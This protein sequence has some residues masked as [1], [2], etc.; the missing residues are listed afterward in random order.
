MR[1]GEACPDD[2]IAIIG[3]A[4]R[5]PGADSPEALWQIVRD[6]RDA[7][8]RFTDEQLAAAG[9]DAATLADPAYVRAKGMVAEADGFDAALFGLSPFEAALMD[10]QQRLFVECAWMALEDAAVD[11]ARFDGAVGMFAGSIL[12]TYLL[13]NL[14]PNRALAQQAGSFQLAVGNDPTFLA[15]R[16]SYLLGLTGPSTSVGTAC[17]TGLTAVHLAC[18]SL[19]AH[20][21]D[22]AL[23]G[24]A[25]VHLPLVAGY[26]FEPGSILS[27]DGHCRPFDAEAQGTVS[28]DGAGAVALRRLAD[29]V[30][31]G[32]PIQAVILGSAINNDGHDKVGFTAPSV[33]PQARV[34][35]E[36][37]TVAGVAPESIA[38]IEA[39]AAG[40]ALGDPIEVAALAEVFAHAPR[41]TPCAIGSIKSNIGHVDAA[42]GIA[43]LIK[44]VLA[45][46]HR[47]LP[48]TA[49]YCAP[50]P[51]LA[52]GSS[53][54]VLGEARAFDAEAPMRAGVSAFG[55]G[56]TNVHIV[57]EEYV[58][59]PPKPAAQGPELLL[60]SA[61]SPGALEATAQR[62]ANHL[63]A[64]P[65]LSLGD[66]AH[67][68]R[69]GRRPLPYRSFVVARD[70]GDAIA[71]LRRLE[72]GEMPTVGSVAFLFPGLGDH[73]P[74]MGWELYCTQPL[75]RREVDRCAALLLPE[76]GGDIR[77]H[78]FAR[79]DWRHPE[80][81]PTSDAPALDLRAMLGRTT[82]EESSLDGPRWGQ[83]A[84]FV[85]EYALAQLLVDWGAVPTT[86]A[87]YSIGEFVAATLAG[88]FALPDAL[89]LVAAR[90]QLID[91]RVERG[92]MLAVSIGEAALGALLPREVSIAAVNGPSLTIAAGPVDAIAAL[93]RRLI[94]EEVACQHLPATHAYHSAMMAPIV[95][96]LANRVAAAEPQPPRTPW[97]SCLTGDWIRAE[98]AIDPHYWAQHLCRTVRFHQALEP[99]LADPARILI[100]LG[101]GQSLT[102]HALAVRTR[103]GRA[104]PVI[105]AMRW[106]YGGDGEAATLQRAV[107]QLWAAGATLDFGRAFARA[108]TRRIA[109]PTYAFQRVRHWIDPPAA[110]DPVETG[111][112]AVE[113]WFSLPCWK[114]APLTQ[115]GKM[116]SGDW[117]IFADAHG[118]GAEL[119]ER[120]R[121]RGGRTILVRP[122]LAFA[123]TAD[124]FTVAPGDAADYGA[125]VASLSQAGD[126]PPNIAHC[127]AL[128]A[129]RDFADTQA[130]G[131]ES[132]VA[133]LAALWR[134]D[135]G[136]SLRVEV[137]ASG[138]ADFGETVPEKATLL[139]PVLVAPQERPGTRCRCIDL[140]PASG[141]AV[142]AVVAE[143][144][145]EPTA[146]LV[147]YRGKARWLRGYE[148]VRLGPVADGLSP[149]RDRGVY[150]ITGGLGGVGLVLARHL[151]ERCAARL[152]LVGRTSLGEGPARRIA[153]VQALEE[154][155]AEVLTLSADVADRAAMAKVFAAAEARFGAVQ[156]VFHCAGS[157]GA[158]TFCEMARMTSADIDAQL[159]AKARG[160]IVL[161][162]V[163]AGRALD[164][165]VLMS[166]LSAV[167][168]GLGF[169]A[170]AAANC[171]LDAFAQD[172]SRVRRTRWLSIDWD[173]WR[174]GE[175]RAAVAGL[176]GTVAD[177]FMQGGEAADACERILAVAGVP[178]VVVSSGD[179]R[180]RLRQWVEHW[181]ETPSAT[182]HARPAMRSRH[183]APR[184]PVEHELAQIWQSLFLIEGIGVDDNFFELGG[185]SLL[186]TQLNARIAR[187]L[188][189]ELSLAGILRAPTIAALAEAVRAA[190]SAPDA[191][192]LLA[193]LDDAEI[194]RLLAVE[195][196]NG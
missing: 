185:N 22:L 75:F 150:L 35:A 123:A 134:D 188:G 116:P 107:G 112:R 53:F 80:L 166:S 8:T 169:A 168:G 45:L 28:S 125:L 61:R 73:Y 98:E 39:H 74:A 16:T 99:L 159:H 194:E 147:T 58:P 111:R 163:I 9:V 105:P 109:L 92:A 52:L 87:G 34:I 174:L 10:P 60:L 129:H 158:D 24:A 132:V 72:P 156:G 189:V 7:I 94:A 70:C 173:S 162:Q 25:S 128:D 89:A 126:V 153:A 196:G 179:L 108:D 13:R 38:L 14:W 63:Q 30:A 33:A 180:Q 148:P 149:L 91:E 176:G 164:F 136:R 1:A 20:E 139:G 152:V 104:N 51:R 44:A 66:V 41:K 95:V 114:P 178:N 138:V 85:V 117:L 37:L 55:I 160:A 187:T 103:L 140:D 12:S 79:H 90:A 127:W 175:T 5:F 157:I 97:V 161:D 121:P 64:H 11:P 29:A 69:S 143:L 76:L 23:A 130:H 65:E 195:D 67:T 146:P 145:V 26:R 32:D 119:A 142:D 172:R 78:L 42:A 131:I 186:A 3:A 154:A 47:T 56:G 141:D 71:Q 96:A 2:A 100:E 151:A 144:A 171:F 191:E 170:Y 21:C 167:L 50:S 88:V 181:A 135:P 59:N 6:G 15:T 110:D 184:D 133:L 177:Y 155:G 101:P 27:P 192:D 43:G 190:A 54:E 18:Q 193:R 102:S 46:R 62:L 115:E 118:I 182:L 81:A 36:A 68:L 113:D 40:T 124:G 31:D 49:H 19:L 82:R 48:P 4:C 120:L 165:C 86:M 93:E 77:D 84:I 183:V 17:S 57:L 83:P 137:L 106:S 122:G